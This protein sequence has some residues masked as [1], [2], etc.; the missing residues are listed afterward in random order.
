MVGWSGVFELSVTAS[1]AIDQALFGYADG[2]RQMASSVRLPPKDLYLLSSASDLASGARL[3]ERDSY[4]TGLP[5]P[6]SRRYALFR[7]WSAPEMPRPGCV[8]SHVILLAPKTVASLATFS[9]LLEL[10]RRPLPS[11]TS[12]YGEPLKLASF[13]SGELAPIA[14]I[15][16]IISDY[17]AGKRVNLSPGGWEAADIENAVL[18]VWSQ[19]WPRLRATYS[20]CT[21]FVKD[22]RRPEASDYDIQVASLDG[23]L[24][25][26]PD[27]DRWISFA[28]ADAAENKVTPLR[29][30]LWRYGRDLANSRRQYRTLVELFER[31]S[32][33]EAIPMDVASTLFGA[34]PDPADG[35]VLKRDIMG[36]GPSSPRLIPA[37]PAVDFLRLLTSDALLETPA[38][39]QVAR[40][41]DD[42]KSTD[43]GVVARFYDANREALSPWKEVVH[44]AIVDRADK[45][46]LMSDF[47]AAILTDVLLERDDLVDMDTLRLA[48]NE[49][50]V[51][52]LSE[53]ASSKTHHA[54]LSEV[55]R[56]DMGEAG[57]GIIATSPS[58]AFHLAIAAYLGNGLD[59]SWLRSFP[60]FSA[61]ILQ[62]PWLDQMQTTAELGAALAILR[63]PRRL[64]KQPD[65]IARRFSEMR[66]EAKGDDRMN[67]QA[68]LLRAAID[69][70]SSKSWTLIT[71]V[72]PELRGF[73]LQ[74]N[75][76]STAHA[77][78]RDDL[79]NFYSAGYWDIDKRILLSLSKLYSAAPDPEALDRLSLSPHDRQ[80]VL[81]EDRW[82]KNPFARLWDWS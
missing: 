50:L 73:I 55:L 33:A 3:G 12:S 29:R 38:A 79:P 4:L 74:D 71:Q 75:L 31:W 28:A 62:G 43:V 30:F 2:H 24:V 14:P 47:P 48:T 44:S 21:A 51:R 68:V 76:P 35:A 81:G 67:M 32:D 25:S 72:L 65:E 57:S 52:L 70:S 39:A 63:Y 69:E 20:F 13:R 34:L 82:A 23:P 40:R 22:R 80:V 41:L 77:L 78:L 54:V 8:W 37:I 10:F 46:T 53:G 56:R 11:E 45:S 6:E 49:V 5:L 15:S 19:Q 64:S 17:Y 7:T 60:P 58:I 16:T 59:R 18:A 66:D 36:L 42:L 27:L 1:D 61:T 9:D 26:P